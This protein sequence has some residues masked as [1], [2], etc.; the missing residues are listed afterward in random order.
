MIFLNFFELFLWLPQY[1]SFLVSFY[2]YRNYF[3]AP[4]NNPFLLF[5][6]EKIRVASPEFTSYALALIFS[7]L[8]K[9][10][11]VLSLPVFSYSPQI[12][13]SSSN[14]LPD[15]QA[16]IYN[17]LVGIHPETNNTHPS[18]RSQHH[19]IQPHRTMRFS[20]STS[21]SIA[22]LCYSL[23]SEFLPYLT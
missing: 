6:I 5:T 22:L 3:Q 8:S 14:L 2:Y 12:I 20:G 16:Q 19:V 9:Y 18:S 23:F 17:H 7:T 4:L 1:H 10:Y 13:S 21:C 11:H 15:T